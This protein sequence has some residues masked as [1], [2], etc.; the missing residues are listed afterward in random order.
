MGAQSFVHLFCIQITH[1]KIVVLLL[2][3]F[4][5]C[6]KWFLKKI[7]HDGRIIH[8]IISCQCSSPGFTVFSHARPSVQ[9]SSPSPLAFNRCVATKMIDVV[10]N[11]AHLLCLKVFLGKIL[12]FPH[13][14]F[15][16]TLQCIRSY[17]KCVELHKSFKMEAYFNLFA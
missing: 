3:F 12:N 7:G 8:V 5:T 9:H 16:V 17:I 11:H 2:V 10:T 4:S 13:C 1:T 6:S 14:A 15:P